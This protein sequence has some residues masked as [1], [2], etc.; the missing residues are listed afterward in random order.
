[1]KPEGN[2]F[3]K[4]PP[5]RIAPLLAAG[6]FVGVGVLS[7]RCNRCNRSALQRAYIVTSFMDKR[8]FLIQHFSPALVTKDFQPSSKSAIATGK[9][10]FPQQQSKMQLT[11][12]GA[13]F[14]NF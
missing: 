9:P 2:D 6:L 10:A 12:S 1:M 3:D 8:S 11:F 5:V 13:A 4:F 14:L 7:C